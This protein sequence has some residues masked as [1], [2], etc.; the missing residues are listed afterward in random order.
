MDNLL[1]RWI[2]LKKAHNNP[3]AGIPFFGNIFHKATRGL[4]FFF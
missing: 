1:K 2:K 4:A 3:F